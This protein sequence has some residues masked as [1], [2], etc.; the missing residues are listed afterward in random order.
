MVLTIDNKCAI[1]SVYGKG[2]RQQK[3]TIRH[4]RQT[5]CWRNIVRAGKARG[6]AYYCRYKQKSCGISQK[7]W[8]K[9][10]TCIFWR[11]NAINKIVWGAI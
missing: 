9:A 1:M 11:N 6:C 2:N 5:F 7:I 4:K 10:T 8:R 3:E